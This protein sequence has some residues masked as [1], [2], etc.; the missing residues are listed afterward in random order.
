[1]FTPLQQQSICGQNKQYGFI[2]VLAM[3]QLCVLMAFGMGILYFAQIMQQN[4]KDYAQEVSMRLAATSE[5]ERAGKLLEDNPTLADNYKQS[6]RT[7][8]SLP[9]SAQALAYP[10]QV[11]VL[12]YD[13]NIYFIGS[14]MAQGKR[15]WQQQKIV[16]GLWKKEGNRYV[17]QGWV[18]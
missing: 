11:S 9:A 17:F 12:R 6:R 16:K 15:V 18:P 14:A 8:V 5:V 4:S 1:M 2:S 13:D 7:N 3:I 10:V